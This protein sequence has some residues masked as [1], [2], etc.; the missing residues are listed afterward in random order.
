MRSIFGR[1]ITTAS[2]NAEIADV[3]T[4][5]AATSFD[6]FIKSLYDPW[7][8]SSPM[9]SSAVFIISIEKTTPLINNIA[10]NSM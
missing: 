10:K 4:P 8:T 6:T 9:A 1:K 2:T 3:K 5:P 7:A